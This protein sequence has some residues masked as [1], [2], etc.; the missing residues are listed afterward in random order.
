ML[1]L[2]DAYQ[3]FCFIIMDRFIFHEHDCRPTGN[4]KMQNF[5]LTFVIKKDSGVSAQDCIKFTV[6]SPAV[7]VQGGVKRNVFK[8]YL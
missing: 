5:S 1:P 4:R 8:D 3:K 7:D 6:N 2:F